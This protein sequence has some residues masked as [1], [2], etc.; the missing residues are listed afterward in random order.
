MALRAGSQLLALSAI[1][2]FSRLFFVFR[3]FA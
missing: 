2:F 1:P 3:G